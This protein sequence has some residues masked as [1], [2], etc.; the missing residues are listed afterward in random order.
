MPRAFALDGCGGCDPLSP[1]RWDRGG[2]IVVCER[3]LVVVCE[4]AL[5]GCGGA[6]RYRRRGATVLASWSMYRRM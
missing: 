6:T 5:G 2:P 1:T 4:R 3:A